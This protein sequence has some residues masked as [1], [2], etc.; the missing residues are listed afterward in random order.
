MYSNF[1]DLK[2]YTNIE[3]EFLNKWIKANRL[4]MN[5]HKIHFLHFT[6]N[7]SPEMDLDISYA[8][9]LISQEYDT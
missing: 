6:P 2:N 8:N 7:N 3:F 9:E 4:S 1:K 5:F